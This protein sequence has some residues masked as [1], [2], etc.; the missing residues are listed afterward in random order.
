MNYYKKC[1]LRLFFMLDINHKMYLYPN[2]V[3]KS[4]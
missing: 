1:S 4:G 2:K 3:D